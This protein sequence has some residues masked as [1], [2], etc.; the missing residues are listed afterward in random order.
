MPIED[1]IIT[2]YC[3]IADSYTDLVT[4]PLRSRGF[5]TKLSDAEV[6]TMEIVGEFMGK[7][8]DKG[9][10]R[11]FY[12]HWHHWFP[13]VGSRANFVK[14][15][16][17]LWLIK[18]RILRRL[19]DTMGAYDDRLH[20]I[21]GFPMPVCKLTR[22]ARSHCFREEAGYS[23]CAAKDEKYYGFE[24]HIIINSQGVISGFTFANASIDERDV[25]QD[26]TDGIHG[27]LIGDKGYI[28]PLLS[29]ELAQQQIDLQT[30]L[31]KNMK[32]SRPKAFVKQ[33]M[34]I[35]RLVETVIAQLSDRFHI[36]KMR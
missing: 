31:R 23:Y 12:S 19:A 28:R 36:E 18:D 24:G 5:P 20:L 6:I 27:L 32:E 9:L 29:E 17:N 10:W 15:S 25:V 22:A 30:P 3:C 14:Q 4:S 8:T 13:N 7:E 1:F 34:S 26:M 11:Y 16:A 33:I 2:V 21:D 35:R